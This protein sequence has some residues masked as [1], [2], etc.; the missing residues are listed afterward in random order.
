MKK[1]FELWSAC[2]GSMSLAMFNRCH[3]LLCKAI[4][5]GQTITDAEGWI[6][7]QARVEK[8]KKEQEA[9]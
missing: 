4:D 7:S 2:M 1:K 3:R 8:V 5:E 9:S 6:K